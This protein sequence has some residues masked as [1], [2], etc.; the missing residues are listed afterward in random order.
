MYIREIKTT[1]KQTGKVYIKHVLTES[2]RINGKS[3][4]RS[5][6]QLG[7]L[8]LPQDLWKELASELEAR[9]RGQQSLNL[10][11]IKLKKN[12]QLLPTMQ[13]QNIV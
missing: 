11:G 12:L 9:I 7:R 1:N 13:C 2:V 10:R 5:I 3:K 6:M 4:K 8:D